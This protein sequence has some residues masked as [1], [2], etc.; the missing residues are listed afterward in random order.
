MLSWN[1]KS[2]KKKCCP[3]FKDWF[4]DRIIMLKYL[5]L[6]WRLDTLVIHHSPHRQ[7]KP[8]WN[9]QI[10]WAILAKVIC[11]LILGHSLWKTGSQWTH[12]PNIQ[13]VRKSTFPLPDRMQIDIKYLLS[14]LKQLETTYIFSNVDG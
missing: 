10:G 4:I 2:N 13:N 1:D 7:G 11:L 8:N 9:N 12:S 3:Q 14:P 6:K 5:C